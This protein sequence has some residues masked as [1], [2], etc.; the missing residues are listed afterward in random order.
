MDVGRIAVA[1]TAL[2]F[3]VTEVLVTIVPTAMVTGL[4]PVY[5]TVILEVLALTDPTV[6]EVNPEVGTKVIVLPALNPETALVTPLVALM[7]PVE[8]GPRETIAV[9]GVT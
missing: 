8:P 5:A 9:V 3:G 1:T 4:P 6:I 7:I 2:K